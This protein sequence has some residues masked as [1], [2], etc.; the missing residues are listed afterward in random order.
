MASGS[1]SIVVARQ[2]AAS[3]RM[4]RLIGTTSRVGGWRKEG[5]V[6]LLDRRILIF[7]RLDQ[8]FGQR[9]FTIDKGFRRSN[10]P[11]GFG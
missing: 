9:K 1:L 4:S 8:Y 10:S 11:G 3:S 6:C 7:E 2:R 5:L